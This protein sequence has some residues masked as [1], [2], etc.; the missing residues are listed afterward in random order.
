MAGERRYR[1]NRGGQSDGEYIF[2]RPCGIYTSSH[3]YLILS[4]DENTQSTFIKF[5]SHSLC[6]SFCGS[7][8]PG[9]II[10]SH[11]IPMLYEPERLFLRNSV[12]MLNW[13]IQMLLRLCSSTICS[14]I[15]Y[16]YLYTETSIL[17]A[18]LWHCKSCDWNNDEYDKTKFLVVMKKP[19]LWEHHTKSCTEA[20]QQSWLLSK[21]PAELRSSLCISRS[22]LQICAEVSGAPKF[23]YSISQIS[24]HLRMLLQS[25]RALCKAPGGSGSI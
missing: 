23:D 8:T 25:L 3:F 24:E 22:L 16:M 11:P 20:A 21:Y 12:W 14:Q 18:I 4:Y 17:Y 9:N 7:S 2:G 6:L 19:L 15:D 10:S 5:L 1:G 13:R